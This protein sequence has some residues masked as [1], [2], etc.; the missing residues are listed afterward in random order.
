MNQ[1]M[2]YFA[3]RVR[4]NRWVASLGVC[5]VT[6]LCTTAGAAVYVDET[7]EDDTIGLN[8]ADAAREGVTAGVL[9]AAG[10]GAIGTDKVAELLDASASG[11]QYLEYNA[12]GSARGDLYISFDVLNKNPIIPGTNSSGT[13]QM[14][15]SVGSWSTSG[16]TT[17]NSNSKRSFS[18]DIYHDGDK[19]TLKIRGASASTV[20]T[21]A[22]DF[23]ELQQ[24][25]IFINDDDSVAM[26]YIRPDDLTT[27]SL[28]AN[29]FAVWVNGALLSPD[30]AGAVMDTTNG[31]TGDTTGDATVGRF[32]FITTTAVE[33][34]FLI[35]NV[36]ASDVAVPEPA[37][38]CL[39]GLGMV[40]VAGRRRR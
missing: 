19:N 14:T 27:Q 38:L 22:Y 29:S 1:K 25:E 35:D 9:T 20:L 11:G 3:S 37:S 16:G 40:L 31:N 30:A 32:G 10:S 26:D 8:P 23:A 39:V 6:A 36:Y 4:V 21:T 34:N 7:F 18:M 2:S 12:G 33:A 5:A 17:L 13:N 15:F 28:N 24:F